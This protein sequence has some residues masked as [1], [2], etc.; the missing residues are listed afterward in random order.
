MQKWDLDLNKPFCCW[1]CEAMNT[2]LMRIYIDSTT[3][4]N[5]LPISSETKD[6]HNFWPKHSTFRFYFIWTNS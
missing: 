3:L 1:G 6:A 5:D 2:Y 4:A